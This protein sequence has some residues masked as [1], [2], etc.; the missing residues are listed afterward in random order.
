MA[1]GAEEAGEE[2][3]STGEPE[4]AA[5]SVEAEEPEAVLAAA[6]APD[7][8]QGQDIEILMP[9]E[10]APSQPSKIR[11]AEEIMAGREGRAKKKEVAKKEAE[12]KESGAKAKKA[13]HKKTVYY[14]DED[15]EI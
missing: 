15:V 8:A 12:G 13:K 9:V 4:E 2:V 3:I 1:V 14:E 10:T 7:Q 5:V 11:F 6:A